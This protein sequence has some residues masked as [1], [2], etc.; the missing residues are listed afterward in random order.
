M[1]TLRWT[2]WRSYEGGVRKLTMRPYLRRF[3]ILRVSTI[4]YDARDHTAD[5]TEVFSTVGAAE[6][7]CEERCGKMVLEFKRGA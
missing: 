6:R 3:S 5:V 2:L 4:H 1:R 7:W